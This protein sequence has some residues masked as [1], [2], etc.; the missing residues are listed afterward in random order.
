MFRRV[1]LSS[2]L[3]GAL[4][5]GSQC[6]SRATDSRCPGGVRVAF[7]QDVA[8]KCYYL[9]ETDA[10]C[11]SDFVCRDVEGDRVCLDMVRAEQVDRK[12]TPA[13]CELVCEARAPVC[14]GALS[15]WEGSGARDD[16]ACVCGD[17][18]RVEVDC[19]VRGQSCQYGHCVGGYEGITPDCEAFAD[20]HYGMCVT[21]V[22]A[23]LT[24]E[25]RAKAEGLRRAF[26][27][28]VD[29]D[30]GEVDSCL[31]IAQGPGGEYLTEL[32]QAIR[33]GGYRCVPSERR[34]Q[35]C[36]LYGDDACGCAP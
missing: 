34:P 10:D 19:A 24:D 28:G 2:L 6:E 21:R 18:E 1:L 26:L 30:G 11:A 25:T 5:C 16:E 3:M 31:E 22:C 15:V 35:L 36:A 12:P 23:G 29:A 14:E 13:P 7:E 9:C 33:G 4:A 8:A 27:E 20:I 17:G 32:L